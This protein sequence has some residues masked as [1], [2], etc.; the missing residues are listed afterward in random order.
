MLHLPHATTADLDSAEAGI[1]HDTRAPEHARH[2]SSPAP[3]SSV[4]IQ[5]PQT[6]IQMMADTVLATTVLLTIVIGTNLNRMPAGLGE[7][8]SLRVSIK[9][10]LLLTLF[11]CAWPFLLTC[12]GVYDRRRSGSE[13]N[14]ISRL[15]AGCSLGTAVALVFPLTSVSGAARLSQLWMFWASIVATGIAMR[16]AREKWSTTRR[17]HQQVRVVI[18]GAGRR[19]MELFQALSSDTDVNYE[20]VG[21]VDTDPARLA[22]RQL[23][24]RPLGTLEELERLLMGQAIDEVFIALPVGSHYRQIQ[25]AI[26]VCEEAGVRVK[27]PADLFDVSLAQ[28]RYESM[29]GQAVVAMHMVADGHA[30]AVKRA[31][32]IVG[33]ATLLLLAAPIM[34]CAALAIKLTSAGPV[35]FAQERYGLNK[36]RF[37]MFK[38]RTMVVDAERLQT[39]LERCNEADG[40]VFKIR[41]DPRVTW[42]GRL[43]RS[44]SIDELPQLWNVLCGDMSLVGPRPLPVRDVRRFTR[45]ADMRRFSVR[46]GLTCLWQVN[47]RSNIGF[48]EW[49]EMDL[50]YIDKWSLTLDLIILVRTIP[51]VLRGTGAS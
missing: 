42:I 50:H 11:T 9:N 47:G 49:M 10:V 46:P 33:A 1:P 41:S 29:Q 36:R 19:A 22:D 21:F 12:A 17:A 6:A 45:P 30:V 14:E 27:Y 18:I 26:R 28:P 23:C 2:G 48:K 37:H 20:V 25:K 43:L 44:T 32:D 38:F 13:M 4:R 31:L 51:A 8:L 24:V 40:P 5:R 7:F 16:V 15:L 3:S 39:D 34:A 35:I